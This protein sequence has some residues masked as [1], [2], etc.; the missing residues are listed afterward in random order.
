MK[1]SSHRL[2]QEE[3]KF[4]RKLIT[5]LTIVAV[6]GIF[7]IFFG[8]PLLAKVVY[9]TSGTQKQTQNTSDTS[10]ALLPPTLDSI[11]TATNSAKINVSGYSISDAAIIV[12][13]NGE[14]STK[15]PT[16]KDGKFNSNE[17]SLKEGENKINAFVVRKDQ[18]SSP[19]ATFIVIYKK[20]NPKIEISSP[21][22]GARIRQDNRDI[23]ISG[24]TDPGNRMTINDR[25]VIV[26]NDGSFNFKVTL[27]DGDNAIQLQ[28]IDE[29]GNITGQ[30]LKVNFSS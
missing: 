26:Q 3:K 13:V 2:R 28:A 10:L 4:T 21:E 22:N 9:F 15:I 24:T 1:L 18:E 14:E 8:L 12:V 27:T 23:T 6:S 5:S 19:S 30:E 7:V 25:L 17:I 11:S 16:D 29:A 20:S